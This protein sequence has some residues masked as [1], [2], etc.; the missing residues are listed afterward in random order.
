MENARNDKNVH[1]IYFANVAIYT[2]HGERTRFFLLS[3]EA[4]R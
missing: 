3:F 4:P 1:L 2:K